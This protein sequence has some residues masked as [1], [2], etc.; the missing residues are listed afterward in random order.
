MSR[1]GSVCIALR[2]VLVAIY[3]ISILYDIAE[4]DPQVAQALARPSI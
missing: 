2:G 3:L 1:C 4:Y